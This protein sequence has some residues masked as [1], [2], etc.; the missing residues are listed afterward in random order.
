[1]MTEQEFDRL[2]QRAEAA[3][4]AARLMDSYPA[5]RRNQRL[6]L[7]GV[8]TV[9]AAVAVAWPLMGSP[10]VADDSYLY[11]YCNRPEKTNQYWVE[12]ADALLMEAGE[13]QKAI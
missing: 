8:A 4:H 11:A 13:P 3:P 9:A 2:W 5:W 1:M 6:A 10:R 12:M 7:G